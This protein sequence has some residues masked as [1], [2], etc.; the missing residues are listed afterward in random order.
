MN[1]STYL[2]LA[3]FFNQKLWFKLLDVIFKKFFSVADQDPDL[4][5]SRTYW[6]ES[7]PNLYND[8]GSRSGSDPIRTFWSDPLSLS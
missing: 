6:S 7:I 4:I 1:K 5:R 8:D 3:Q 2:Q